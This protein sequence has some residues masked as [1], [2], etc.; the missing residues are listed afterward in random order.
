MVFDEGQETHLTAKSCSQ[1]GQYTCR[2]RCCSC[3]HQSY[4]SSQTC[5]QQIQDTADTKSILER[6]QNGISNT[7]HLQRLSCGVTAM[8]TQSEADINYGHAARVLTFSMTSIGFS[9]TLNAIKAAT[10]G[11]CTTRVEREHRYNTRHFLVTNSEVTV[12]AKHST[13]I[14]HSS[15]KDSV[16]F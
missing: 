3:D 16:H 13:N 11:W 14:Q 6:I 7:Q 4:F 12:G 5:L 2:Y 1:E 8:Q 15:S 9:Y 10:G